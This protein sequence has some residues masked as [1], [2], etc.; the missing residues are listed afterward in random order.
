MA[1]RLGREQQSG[2]AVFLLKDLPPDHPARQFARTVN[3][4]F[5]EAD[6]VPASRAS[7]EVVGFDLDKPDL[8][9]VGWTTAIT[10]E[11]M[12][13]WPVAADPTAP[14]APN[15]LKQSGEV[16]KSSFPLCFRQGSRVQDSF[17]E[18]KFKTVSGKVDQAAGVV[19]RAKDATNY[20]LCRANALED[21]VVLYKVENG[22]R[23]SLDIVGRTGGY[24]VDTKVT[25]AQWNTLRVEFAGSRF[26]AQFD[27]KFLVEVEDATF[28]DAGTVGLWTKADSVTA[29][30]DFRYGNSTAADTRVASI[31][32][33]HVEGAKIVN[34]QGREVKLRGLQYA[35]RYTAERVAACA[36][37]FKQIKTWGA[38]IVCCTL[39][40]TGPKAMALELDEMRPGVYETNRLE[41]LRQMIRH[42][43][44]AGLY[45]LVQM[46]VDPG[47]NLSWNNPGP[48]PTIWPLI[49]RTKRVRKP[50][51]A[52]AGSW[53]GFVARWSNRNPT[54]SA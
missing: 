2:H 31:G 9:P 43:A 7:A 20:Y 47:R 4:K 19:W 44:Q 25:P 45:V 36:A 24:G 21:N 18:V 50:P 41:G 34:S 27:S 22:K 1:E 39:W 54:S 33:L 32:P 29:F 26:K 28:A 17:V 3:P 14:S 46:R 5:A 6:S 53:S 8:P 16:P 30:D 15:V 38:N 12:L 51:N 35:G 37:E 42:A 40:W 48:A 49:A 10:G 52:P 13:V 23:K 11:G